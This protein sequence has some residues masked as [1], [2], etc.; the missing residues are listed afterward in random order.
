M[1]VRRTLWER[2]GVGRVLAAVLAATA[3]GMSLGSSVGMAAEAIEQRKVQLAAV[4]DTQL[5]AQV[6]IADALGFFKDEGLDM[7]V[8]W[9]T[10]GADI[11]TFM[12]GGATYLAAGGGFTGIVL[13]TQGTPVKVIAGLADMAGTQGLALAPGLKLSSP[14]ELEGKK[15]A[16]TQGTPNVLI[17]S[18]MA[19]LYGFDM[20]K[21]QLI[22]ME[23][24]EGAV[25]SAKGDVNGFLGFQPHLQRLVSLGGT[26]YATGTEVYF[27]GTPEKLA[28]DK[29]LI[30]VHSVLLASQE[31]IDKRPNTL[32]AAMRAILKANDVIAT[33]MPKASAIMQK[34]LKLDEQ[35]IN[36]MMAA[37]TYTM[38]I[39]DHLAKSITFQS[40]WG[41]SIKRIPSEVTPAQLFEPKLLRDIDPK[42]VTWSASK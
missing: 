17:L 39:D 6:A 40:D 36:V 30:Y 11:I 16:F 32:K 14:K 10:S 37:N 27:G 12:A 28:F 8:Q 31:W 22:S 2:T 13:T 21:I 34:F 29:R 25:A 9:T 5:G 3:L 19:E 7:T 15:L 42:L 24:P 35:S 20:K 26:L 38:A 4:R 33:D 41:R 23:P 18:K 1:T